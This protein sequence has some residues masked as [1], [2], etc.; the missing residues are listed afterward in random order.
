MT[1]PLEATATIARAESSGV[2]II[3]REF[4]VLTGNHFCAVIL[5]Q[6][7]YWTL[8]VKDF[9]NLLREERFYNA[10]CNTAPRHGWIYKTAQEL[11]QETMLG[12]SP[13]SIRKYLKRSEERRVGK[14]CV[15][16]CRSRWSPYH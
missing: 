2:S 16:T 6:L 1:F 7:L 5:N 9:D 15:S 3:R 8:R 11:N 13:P 14:E 12:L 4:V 10:E